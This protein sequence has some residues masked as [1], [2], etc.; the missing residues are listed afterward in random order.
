MRPRVGMGMRLNAGEVPHT[1]R[2]KGEG[3]PGAL[4]EKERFFFYS[5]I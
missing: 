3:E 5:P 2:K 1:G 4:E